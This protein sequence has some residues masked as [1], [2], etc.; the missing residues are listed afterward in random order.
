MWNNDQTKYI[1]SNTVVKLLK[2]QWLFTK[3][4]QKYSGKNGELDTYMDI[5]IPV[6]LKQQTKYRWL[7]SCMHALA[8]GLVD[9]CSIVKISLNDCDYTKICCVKILTWDLSYIIHDC[10]DETQRI[11]QKSL[12]ENICDINVKWI[13]K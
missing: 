8:K 2:L 3:Y 6:S 9:R 10:F 4:Q 13:S 1:W 7:C 12:S 11:F 5:T